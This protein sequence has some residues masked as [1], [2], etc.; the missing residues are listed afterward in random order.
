MLRLLRWGSTQTL[1]EVSSSDTGVSFLGHTLP[2]FENRKI[3]AQR[4]VLEENGKKDI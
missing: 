2:N 3:F 4:A 1:Y